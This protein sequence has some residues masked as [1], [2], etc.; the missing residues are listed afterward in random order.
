[1]SWTFYLGLI[2]FLTVVFSVFSAVAF[3]VILGVRDNYL[4]YYQKADLQWTAPG[5]TGKRPILH[6]KW[7]IGMAV[8]TAWVVVEFVIKPHP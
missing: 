3:S 4:R 6:L 7:L 5:P 2:V 8:V 1:M